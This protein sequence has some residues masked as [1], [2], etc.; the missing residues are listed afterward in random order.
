[1]PVPE[2]FYST[3][4]RRLMSN[5]LTPRNE[6]V[7]SA[8]ASTATWLSEGGFP[9]LRTFTPPSE[10]TS[11]GAP[12]ASAPHIAPYSN[13]GAPPRAD[14]TALRKASRCPQNAPS[15]L[16]RSS[17]EFWPTGPIGTATP[18]GG[19]C[20]TRCRATCAWN[21]ATRRRASA[22]SDSSRCS[23]RARPRCASQAG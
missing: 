17:T 5:L 13:G 12:R 4:I 7:P 18:R 16:G 9:P 8:R 20:R 15:A 22:R 23:A 14:A 19:P 10:G 6:R 2:H 11:T 3:I 1:M 21:S